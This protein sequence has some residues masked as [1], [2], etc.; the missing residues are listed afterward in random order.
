MWP[1]DLVK[2]KRDFVQGLGKQYPKTP[3]I[4]ELQTQEFKLMFMCDDMMVAHKNHKLIKDNS[5]RVS[6][7]FTQQPF[8]Y[9]IGRYENK[10][11]PFQAKDG[12]KVK[13]EIHAVRTSIIP[14]LDNHYDNGVQFARVRVNI[15]VTDRD[16]KL[17]PIGSEEVVRNLPP[18]MIRTVPELGLRHY[19]SNTRVCVIPA[20]MYVA[21]KVYWLKEPNS[22]P[23]LKPVFPKDQLV[24]LPSYYHY[25]IDK[26]K[27]E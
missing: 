16:H 23:K 14:A 9:R 5:Q 6:R 17:I 15:L 22:F 13:G 12:M 4:A 24:W 26:N 21:I 25:P 19:L 7:G 27:K 11:L 3:D 2:R 10:G 18:G 1:F 8:E 20:D